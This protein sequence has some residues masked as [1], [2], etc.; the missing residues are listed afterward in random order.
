MNKPDLE[1]IYVNSLSDTGETI[2]VGRDK[3]SG[4][5]YICL[6]DGEGAASV[7]RAEFRTMGTSIFDVLIAELMAH[8]TMA[9]AKYDGGNP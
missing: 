9:C 6:R 2:H 7:W 3:N 4:H 5:C 8:P 1:F